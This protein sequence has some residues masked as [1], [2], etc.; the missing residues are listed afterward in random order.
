MSYSRVALLAAAMWLGRPMT[1]CPSAYSARRATSGTTSPRTLSSGR[2][3]VRAPWALQNLM[4]EVNISPQAP[5]PPPARPPIVLAGPTRPAAAA[6][7]PGD[8]PPPSPAAHARV[9][10]D[11]GVPRREEIAALIYSGGA[12]S[13]FGGPPGSARQLSPGNLW[14]GPRALAEPQS[15]RL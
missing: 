2:I 8:L 14:C 5:P 3:G 4:N 1:S 7:P 15:S 11:L 6:P 9:L 13:R 10:R 12:D